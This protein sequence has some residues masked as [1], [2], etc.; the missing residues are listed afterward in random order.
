MGIVNFIL[1]KRCYV[2]T[3]NCLSASNDPKLKPS[4]QFETGLNLSGRKLDIYEGFSGYSPNFVCLQETKTE[5]DC[6]AY[7]NGII[8]S[9]CPRSTRQT[10]K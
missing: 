10:S 5:A 8:V 9:R 4:D 2:I 3:Y 1:Q 6:F 7:S